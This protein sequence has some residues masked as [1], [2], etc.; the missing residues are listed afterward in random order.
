MLPSK[1]TLA[2]LNV[3]GVTAV[4]HSSKPGSV[5]GKSSHHEAADSLEPVLPL[6]SLYEI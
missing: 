6:S 3:T 5:A 2:P 4:S 1:L